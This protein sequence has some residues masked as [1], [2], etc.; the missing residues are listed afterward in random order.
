L[1]G[2]PFP[3]PITY[4]YYFISYFQIIHEDIGQISS[5]KKQLMGEEYGSNGRVSAHVSASP[6]VQTSEPPKKVPKLIYV[7]LLPITPIDKSN[8][9][10]QETHL[11]RDK[12]P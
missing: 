12:D 4:L 1:V 11:S 5:I 7:S 10:L 8:Y 2:Y 6:S 9:I 3:C